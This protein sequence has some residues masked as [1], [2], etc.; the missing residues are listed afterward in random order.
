MSY[1]LFL[2]VVIIQYVNVNYNELYMV[3]KTIPKNTVLHNDGYDCLYRFHVK[4][5]SLQK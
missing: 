1:F 4:F 2:V 3:S 5:T